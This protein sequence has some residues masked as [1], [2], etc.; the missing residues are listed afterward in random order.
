M[1]NALRFLPGTLSFFVFLFFLPLSFS[2]S[3]RVERPV[4]DYGTDKNIKLPEWE[5]HQVFSLC[6]D[7]LTGTSYLE[8]TAFPKKEYPGISLPWLTGDWSSYS[9]LAIIA[10]AHDNRD[11]IPFNVLIFDGRGPFTYNNRL[12][13]KII[14][15]T[16]WTLCETPLSGGLRMPDGRVMDKKHISQV[17]FFTGRRPEP[18]VFDIKEIRLR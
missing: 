12:G 18:T 5:C 9:T 10:R 14:V 4:M 1:L 6:R 13:K 3:R 17:V 8:V 16:A 15:H 7:S 2:C 11:S